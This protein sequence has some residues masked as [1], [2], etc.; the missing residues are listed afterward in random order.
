MKIALRIISIIISF[1]IIFSLVSCDEKTDNT[2]IVLSQKNVELLEIGEQHTLTATLRSNTYD[3]SDLIWSSSDET[4]ATCTDGVI[5]AIGYGVCVIRASCGD[6]SSACTVNIPNPN[7]K[8]TLSEAIITLNALNTSK[9]ITAISENGQDISSK[10]IWKSSNEK[11]AT[12]SNGAIKPISYGVCTITAFLGSESK[13]CIVQITD[14][15]LPRVSINTEQTDADSFKKLTLSEG[16]TLSLTATSSP[17]GSAVK[18]ISSD[19]SIAT[20]ANGNVTAKRSGA[21]LIIATNDKGASDYVYLTVGDF[22]LPKPDES[23]LLFDFPDVGAKIK[24]VDK[25]T[26]QISSISVVTSYS[27]TAETYENFDDRM[28]I[29]LELYCVKV[30]DIAGTGGATP[31]YISTEMYRENDTFCEQRTFK[32]ISCSV[33]DAFVIKYE[34]QFTIQY[35]ED[36]PRVFYMVFNEFVEI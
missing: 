33:G 8:L 3:T 26:G 20:C 30:Y 24:Y 13:E 17:V 25:L 6:V 5:T 11:I 1:S 34:P 27:L 12:C 16:E 4:V 28:L 23:K 22:S 14:P 15:D 10:V 21:C 32:E 7:P 35:S 36:G 18:W 29:T 19:E 9:T 31:A 2:V